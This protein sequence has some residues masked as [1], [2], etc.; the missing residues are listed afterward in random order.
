[1][2]MQKTHVL[3]FQI[4]LQVGMFQ[5]G[6]DSDEPMWTP[7]HANRKWPRLASPGSSAHACTVKSGS[8]K[9]LCFTACPLDSKKCVET[10]LHMTMQKTLVLAFQI[11]L[12]VGMFWRG[13]D[14]DQPMWTPT[15]AN[16][17]WPRSGRQRADETMRKPTNMHTLILWRNATMGWDCSHGFVYLML[18]VVTQ[19]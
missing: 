12:Q 4:Y 2:T 17:K 18:A 3:A 13:Q 7:T 8:G 6:Q 11:Y 14:S 9:A 19:L 16:R 1:M 15:S 10:R 5:R